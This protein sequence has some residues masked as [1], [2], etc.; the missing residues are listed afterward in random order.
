[1]SDKDRPG[2]G[3]DSARDAGSEDAT[4]L[5]SAG[6]RRP[7]ERG[8]PRSDEDSAGRARGTSSASQIDDEDEPTRFRRPPPGYSAVERR[9]AIVPPDGDGA[10]T[11]A[12]TDTDADDATRFRSTMSSG[13]DTR[14]GSFDPDSGAPS[15]PEDEPT[16][17][18]SSPGQLEAPGGGGEDVETGEITRL[19]ASTTSSAGSRVAA[20]AVPGSD[21][22]SHGGENDTT[23]YRSAIDQDAEPT[24][25]NDATRA[26]PAVTRARLDELAAARLRDAAAVLSDDRDSD[27]LDEATRMRARSLPDDDDPTVA[28][29]GPAGSELGDDDATLQGSSAPA[30]DDEE[31]LQGTDPGAGAGTNRRAPLDDDTTLQSPQAGSAR[32]G[33]SPSTARTSAEAVSTTGIG[34]VL[35]GRFTLEDKLGAGGMGGVYKAIDQVKKEAR[36]RNPYVAVK[37]LNESFAEHPDAFIALQRESSRTQKL[38]HPNI[39]SV[40]DFDRDGNVAYMIMELLQ[41]EPLDKHLKANKAGLDREQAR[42]IIRDIASALAYAHAQGLIHSDFKPGN[43]FWTE[44]GTAKVF[45]FGIARAVAASDDP[46]LGAGPVD[47]DSFDDDGSDRTLFDAGKLGALTPAYAAIEM[48][49]GREPASQDDVYALGIVAYQCLTGKHPF[50]RQ[51]APVAEAKSMVPE[52]PDGL[53]RREWSAIRHA[54]AFRREDRTPDAQE[55]LDEFF[56]VTGQ[57]VRAVAISLIGMGALVAGMYFAGIIG[58][59]AAPIEVPEQWVQLETVLGNTRSD[60]RERLDDPN[61]GPVWEEFVKQ[62]IARWE[63]V[64]APLVVVE[65]GLTAGAAQDLRRQIFDQTGLPLRMTETAGTPPTYRLVAGPLDPDSGYTVEEIVEPLE[66]LGLSPEVQ[67]DAEQ[68]AR[69]RDEA[70]GV[71]L[72]NLDRLLP[73]APPPRVR[74]SEDA[75]GEFVA[76]EVAQRAIN[77]Q[78]QRIADARG[79]FRNA[80]E[81]FPTRPEALARVS[82]R[83][84]VVDATWQDARDEVIRALTTAAQNRFL[85]AQQA[86]SERIAAENAELAYQASRRSVVRA[87]GAN[88]DEPA[89]IGAMLDSFLELKPVDREQALVSAVRCAQS[90]L[91]TNAAAVLETRDLVLERVDFA[92]LAALKEPDP[93]SDRAFIGDGRRYVC[94]DVLG[95][96]GTAPSMVVVPRADAS[97][98]YA[99]GKY[100]VSVGEFNSF[101][102]AT[103]CGTPAPGSP[104]APAVAIPVEAA[105]GY[106]GWLSEQTGFEYRLPTLEEWRH[107]AVA[108]NPVLDTN[109]NCFSNVRGVVKGERLVSFTQGTANDWGLI[110]HVGN[111]QEWVTSAEGLR[112]AGGKHTDSLAECTLDRQVPHPGTADRFTGFRLYREVV[113]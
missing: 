71:Y 7:A 35:K 102:S 95:S 26:L 58:P 85:R 20:S 38:S 27:D 99:I 73:D 48:F 84:D 108:R 92:P 24:E 34:T 22:D 17:F 59:G 13:A 46:V 69:A 112:A 2:S 29:G 105:R 50:N 36:D 81:R 47:V 63:T 57:T 74:I 66:A 3:G 104:R 101:C 87:F 75:N 55:F 52:R 82:M 64:A 39:A 60:V 61:F 113:L 110:N 14:S 6:R 15:Y 91:R 67:R 76:D 106:A 88:C 90:K 80:S 68:I 51:K 18:R 109:R 97:G 19:G 62:S 56:G 42:G 78:I 11:D 89:S 23:R 16:L 25:V 28:A 1:M 65:R 21:D 70:L 44:S 41:G 5:R 31:T 54:L 8:G 111:A 100:E 53:T 37:V 4:E 30:S 9:S 103:G 43:I 107:A 10:D 77:T 96:G 86:E 83:I 45:D 94:T 98:A 40:Y 49:E 12:D 93:C 33:T 72:E 32:S 79:Y